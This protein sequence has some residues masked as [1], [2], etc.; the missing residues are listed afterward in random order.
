MLYIMF[1]KMKISTLSDEQILEAY[2]VYLCDM[3]KCITKGK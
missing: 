3:L 1:C 2:I